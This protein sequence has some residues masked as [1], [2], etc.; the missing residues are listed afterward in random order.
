MKGGGAL[1][2]R[3]AAWYCEAMREGPL[4]WHELDRTLVQR[5][6]V[7]D[8]YRSRRRNGHRE[9]D[10]HLL[11][12]RDWANVVPVLE[13]GGRHERFVMVRQYRH[14]IDQV[15]VEFPAGLIELDEGPEA[16]AARELLEETGFRARR[17]V[18]LGA[19]VPNP[20]FM[21]NTCHSFCAE[22]LER[23]EELRLDELEVLEVLEVPLEE[24]QRQIGQAPYVNSMTALALFWYLRYRSA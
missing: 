11:T 22:G 16:A 4:H 24:L 19:I 20:A 7:F 5:C 13:A 14:G 23:V 9:G 12:A 21:N 1:S 2:Q 8:L 6:G 3:P 10:F 18:G 15:T 17:L